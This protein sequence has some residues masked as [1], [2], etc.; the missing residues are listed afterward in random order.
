MVN[1]TPHSGESEPASSE[2]SYVNDN[3]RVVQFAAG[4]KILL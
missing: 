3:L 1:T 4:N 2:D